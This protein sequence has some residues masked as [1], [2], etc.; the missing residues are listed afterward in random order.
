MTLTELRTDH[1]AF[2]SFDASLTH[3]FY[4]EVMGFPLIFAQSGM[5]STWN[6]EYLLTAY[7]I[8]DGRT[9]DFFEFDGIRRPPEDDLPK[10]IRHVGLAVSTCDELERWKSRLDRFE[11]AYTLED[12]GDDEHLY[13]SDPNGV[14][15]EI[16]AEA[17]TLGARAESS[18]ALAVVERWLRARGR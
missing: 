1:L 16:S 2:P 10:D 15:F 6:R 4:S 9:I 5:S 14:L 8:G 12:H 11:I 13:F 18:D 3:R 17:D 7:A